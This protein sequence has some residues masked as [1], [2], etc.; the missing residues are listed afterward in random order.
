MH[1]HIFFCLSLFFGGRGG[2]GGRG[3][4]WQVWGE[5]S[6][7]LHPLDETLPYIIHEVI[8]PT[9]EQA[10]QP[11][12][13]PLPPLT[14]KEASHCTSKGRSASKNVLVKRGSTCRPECHPGRPCVNITHKQAVA[15]AILGPCQCY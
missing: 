6:P 4:S 5:V 3:G 2:E 9:V 15:H 1:M 12:Y 10:S 14:T 13:S 11:T 8:P 7:Y